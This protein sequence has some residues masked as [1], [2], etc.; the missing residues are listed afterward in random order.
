MYVIINLEYLERENIMKALDL[1]TVVLDNSKNLDKEIREQVYK[2]L[3]LNSESEK[4]NEMIKGSLEH[5]NFNLVEKKFLNRLQEVK[6]KLII[7]TTSPSKNATIDY[8]KV[9]SALTDILR[10]IEA[11]VLISFDDDF[12]DLAN[13]ISK[14]FESDDYIN[15]AKKIADRLHIE[16]TRESIR[17]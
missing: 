1:F 4:L 7:F 6:E 15:A 16:P 8:N 9:S 17:K 2:S 10:K 5:F 13:Q 14:R 3:E 11:D 12:V